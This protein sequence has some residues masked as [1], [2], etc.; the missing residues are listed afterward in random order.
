M[1][2]LFQVHIPNPIW[3]TSTQIPDWPSS[4]QQLSCK[5]KPAFKKN[6]INNN[7]IDCS[8][9]LES[10]GHF[11]MIVLNEQIVLQSEKTQLEQFH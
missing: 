9:Q 5:N 8:F 1:P 4:S 3:L 6:K 2:V 11:L 7:Y 10:V